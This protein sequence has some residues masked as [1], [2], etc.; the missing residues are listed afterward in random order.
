MANPASVCTNPV[1]HAPE[2]PGSDIPECT[3]IALDGRL[4]GNR[5]YSCTGDVQSYTW[6]N[7]QTQIIIST[8]QLASY[9]RNYNTT[10][11][12]I[13]L[14]GLETSRKETTQPTTT[15]PTC[16]TTQSYAATT[17]VSATFQTTQSPQ[18]QISITSINTQAYQMSVK[19]IVATSHLIMTMQ[20]QLMF[21]M[22]DIQ[23]NQYIPN[24]LKAISQSMHEITLKY[25]S[26]IG[27]PKQSALIAAL[28][29]DHIGVAMIQDSRIVSKKDGIPPIMYQVV[30]HTS[31]SHQQSVMGY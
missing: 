29:L 23:P 13:R 15:A 10:E 8:N 6:S 26:C 18:Q 17:R 3:T 27:M 2:T 11:E 7:K 16:D 12:A 25:K 20:Q 22:A 14:R 30:I 5:V 28:Q 19:D 24:I 21:Q 31:Y 1:T 9:I 4:S